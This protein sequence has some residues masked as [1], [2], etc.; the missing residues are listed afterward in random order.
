MNFAEVLEQ[1]NILLHRWA[2]RQEIYSYLEKFVDTDVRKADVGIKT[3][4]EGLVVPQ[5][6]IIETRENILADMATIMFKIKT[7]EQ[8]EVAENDD[9]EENAEEEDD[10]GGEGEEEDDG[11]EDTDSGSEE[12]EGDD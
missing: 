7:L 1:R 10:E 6:L 3:E 12:D 9:E 2:I 4:G 5:E 11:D 8:R